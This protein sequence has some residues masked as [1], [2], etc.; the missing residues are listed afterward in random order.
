MRVV[1]TGGAGFI[2][3]NLVHYWSNQYP[4]DDLVVIDGLTY[5]GRRE[6]LADLDGNPRFTFQ[7]ARIED[8]EAVEVHLRGA[9]L[10]INLAAESHNDRAIANPL[11]FVRTNVLGTAVLLEACRKL[12]VP[13]FHHV[14]TDEVY[15]SLE[16]GSSVRFSEGSPYGPRGP[17]SASKAGSDHLVRAWHE[18]YGLRTTISNSGNNFGPF[19]FP[20]K[21]IPLAVTRL[22]RGER[23]PLY[24]D[25]QNV[26]DWI[27]VEDH[28]TAIDRIARRGTPG[29]TYLVSAEK[30]VSNRE[31][32]DLLLKI[33]GRGPDSIQR[34]PDRPGHDR[35]Y[36][37][38]P[39][40]IRS[41][42][43]W[44]PEHDFEAAL[45]STVDWYKENETWWAPLLNTPVPQQGRSV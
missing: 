16:L 33:V 24:G 38:D 21:L 41:E 45:R 15:G 30:E 18:T 23:V 31:L 37:L 40:R 36:G 3:S 39:H 6:S 13:R 17:Y 44:K 26:R 14:S 12:D 34:V 43:G 5:A 27:Y 4:Q 11:P 32:V 25:G 10:I 28:C 20:E 42:L 8:A 7:R 1:I 35:R 9:D 19:Q 22:L 29:A 2:G